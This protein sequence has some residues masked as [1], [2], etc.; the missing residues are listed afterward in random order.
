MSSTPESGDTLAAGLPPVLLVRA[1]VTAKGT[2]VACAVVAEPAPEG[3]GAAA[4]ARAPR[5][6]PR[7]QKRLPDAE[8]AATLFPI[9]AISRTD[10]KSPKAAALHQGAATSAG[11]DRVAALRLLQQRNV[12][13]AGGRFSGN[14][15]VSSG[16]TTLL[17]V[18]KCDRARD[19]CRIPE[20]KEQCGEIADW[21]ADPRPD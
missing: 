1:S 13:A 6:Y 12:A 21:E 5:R 3:D 19:C 10:G 2:A 18:L 8:N 11:A 20:R 9:P 17:V 4:I 16:R 7:E 14:P 15:A